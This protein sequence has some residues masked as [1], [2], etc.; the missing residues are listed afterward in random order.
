MSRVCQSSCA[1]YWYPAEATELRDLLARQFELAV[2]HSQT[3]GSGRDAAFIVPH[4]A[5]AYSGQV[6]AA[7]YLRIAEQNPRR[8]L[9]LGFCHSGHCE[10]IEIPPFEAYR[11]PIGE[12]AVDLQAIDC[13]RGL[14]I[15]TDR[16]A[17]DHSVEVQLPFL[18]FAVPDARILPVF[19]GRLGKAEK[20]LAS[21]AIFELLTPGTV[22]IASSDFT[23]YGRSFG[24]VPFP[25]DRETPRRI[26]ELDMEIIRA[27]GVLDSRDYESVRR[28]APG[29]LCGDFPVSLLIETL[30]RFRTGVVHRILEYAQSGEMTG[31][32]RQSVSYAAVAFSAAPDSWTRGP[33]VEIGVV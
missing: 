24:F 33:E 12:T 29:C 5:P 13:L 11:T 1:G 18:Q 27:I 15:C 22:L 28:R 31:D 14:V 2:K 8:I 7:A 23:H 9:L 21:A 10:G 26:R 3:A 4:A 6:A 20:E 25:L 17:S 19:V 16:P 30:R 32:Y